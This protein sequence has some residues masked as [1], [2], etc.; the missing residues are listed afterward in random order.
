MNVDGI[1]IGKRS[2][3]ILKYHRINEIRMTFTNKTDHMELAR[4][5]HKAI[6]ITYSKHLAYL[7]SKY[8]INFMK[9]QFT[10]WKLFLTSKIG[11]ERFFLKKNVFSLQNS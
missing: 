7:V 5:G 3:D 2:A 9:F 10:K 8:F 4:G 1:S 6:P 11:F